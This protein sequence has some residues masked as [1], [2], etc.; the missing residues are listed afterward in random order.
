MAPSR[1]RMIEI[2]HDVHDRVNRGDLT[3]FA[4]HLSDNYVRHCQAM[5]PE[6]QELCGHE[7]LTEFV[8]EYLRGTPDWHDTIDFVMVD[9]D[10]IAYKTTSTGTQTGPIGDLPAT[11]RPF[12]LVSLIV[13]RFE[14]DKIAETWVSWDNLAILSQ[15]GHLPAP[16]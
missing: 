12:E 4:D 15:L 13:H 11:G 6:A 5:P 16:G 7:A 9:G 8:R 1:E 3:A 14:G 10:R 2:V